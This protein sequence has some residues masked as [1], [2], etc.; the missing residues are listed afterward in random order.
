[1]K[2][3][4]VSEEV[5][6][7]VGASELDLSSQYWHNAITIIGLDTGI[8]TVRAKASGNSV[9]ENVINGEII[10]SKNRTLTIR[11]TQLEALE[12]TITPEAAFTVRVRQADGDTE[13]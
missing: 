2:S 4:N 9:F 3:P 13:R 10:L 12:F 8:M 11:N 7:G 6:S 5:F 1:M